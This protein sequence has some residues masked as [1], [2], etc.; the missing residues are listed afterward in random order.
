MKPTTDY[1]ISDKVITFTFT[2]VANS[3]V[4]VRYGV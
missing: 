2:P 3:Q 1:A 4:M